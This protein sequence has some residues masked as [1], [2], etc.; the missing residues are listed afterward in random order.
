[1]GGDQIEQLQVGVDI[2][3]LGQLLVV[4]TSRLEKLCSSEFPGRVRTHAGIVEP[5]GIESYARDSGELRR[6]PWWC[7]T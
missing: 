3:E 4:L 7:G 1:V 5:W 6:R 2:H